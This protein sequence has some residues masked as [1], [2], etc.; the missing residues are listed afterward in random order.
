MIVQEGTP[1]EAEQR[2]DR[3]AIAECRHED[4]VV[5]EGV[6]QRVPILVGEEVELVGVLPLHGGVVEILE[7]GEPACATRDLDL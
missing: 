1:G 5:A 7:V 6:G 3:V 2:R 4:Q